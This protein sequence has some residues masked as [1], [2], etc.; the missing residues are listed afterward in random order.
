MGRFLPPDGLLVS[1]AERARGSRRIF[2]D[3]RFIPAKGLSLRLRSGR[4]LGEVAVGGRDTFGD[5]VI[6]ER[7]RRR[8][9]WA[10]DLWSC[11][12]RMTDGDDDDWRRALC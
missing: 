7:G 2:A 10:I 4:P 1:A 8:C 5:K 9:S 3:V 11:H 12:D 6:L